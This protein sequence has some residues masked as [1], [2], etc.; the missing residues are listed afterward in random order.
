M[1]RRERDSEYLYLS[2]SGALRQARGSVKWGITQE[3]EMKSHVQH[4]HVRLTSL[5]LHHETLTATL[6]DYGFAGATSN[7]FVTQK[8]P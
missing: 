2:N 5:C 1:S 8:T 7:L 3:R 4:S 6:Q